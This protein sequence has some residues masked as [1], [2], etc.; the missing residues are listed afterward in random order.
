MTTATGPREREA[1]AGRTT[2]PCAT[3][4]PA[5]AR[6]VLVAGIGNVLRGD[7]GFGPAVIDALRARGGLP[8]GVRVVEVGIGGIAL[9]HE[10]MDGY[11]GL[12]LVDAVERG[13]TPGTLYT[14]EPLV[15]ELTT[16]TP[17]E[18][19]ELA[20]DM[21]GAVPTRALLIASAAGVLPPLVRLIGCQP[22]VIEE[23]GLTLSP[24]CQQAVAGAV[25]VIHGLLAEWL[26]P[27]AA[28]EG[29]CRHGR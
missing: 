14:L 27:D 10:L 22:A 1:R 9:V 19:R 5:A 2:A 23:F 3:Q 13:S 11:D 17:L 28:V 16:L 25:A 21:H 4:R 26:Q 15:P 7:D 12:V 29:T 8:A 20:A 24:C 18:Q 6:R